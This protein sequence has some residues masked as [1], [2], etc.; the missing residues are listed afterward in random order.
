M[1]RHILK[2]KS[3]DVYSM[4]ADCPSCNAKTVNPAPAKFSPEDPYGSYR[5]KARKEL[6]ENDG[7]L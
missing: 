2:C 6:L 4:E 3:C 5:R 7:R 1:A